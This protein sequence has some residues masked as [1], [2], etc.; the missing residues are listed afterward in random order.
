MWAHN[1]RKLPKNIF[2]PMRLIVTLILGLSLTCDQCHGFENLSLRE[3]CRKLPSTD[4]TTT[5][6][7]GKNC[8]SMAYGTFSCGKC[9]P[10][11][12][13]EPYVCE[14]CYK[15]TEDEEEFSCNTC[16][17]G[18][19]KSKRFICKECNTNSVPPLTGC[20]ESLGF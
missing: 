9:E 12:M 16:K 11:S 6:N 3:L 13:Y 19:S 4:D 17:F 10:G 8:P 20:K 1:F 14:Y 18:P 15:G 5:T 7:I 2:V